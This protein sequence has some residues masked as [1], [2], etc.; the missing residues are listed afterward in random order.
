[1]TVDGLAIV[2][3]WL[4]DVIP[5]RPDRKMP[6]KVGDKASQNALGSFPGQCLLT[7][8]ALRDHGFSYAQA[9]EIVPHPDDGEGEAA[10]RKAIEH[11]RLMEVYMSR[12]R[13][14][15]PSEGGDDISETWYDKDLCKLAMEYGLAELGRLTLDQYDFIL[16]GGNADEFGQFDLQAVQDDLPR[17]IAMIKAAEERGEIPTPIVV[18]E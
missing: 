6:V 17:R 3:N 12:R 5:G 4:D 8:L 11:F 14:R 13:T 16:S 1:M 10:G 15:T 7:W 18:E 2:I 9:A